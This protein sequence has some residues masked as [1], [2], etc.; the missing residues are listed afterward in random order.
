MITDDINTAH[1]EILGRASG[2]FDTITRRNGNQNRYTWDNAATN[3]S[4]EGRW[5]GADQERLRQ[6][7]LLQNAM[8]DPSWTSQLDTYTGALDTAG[9][10]QAKEGY[11][12]AEGQRRT[13]AASTGRSGGSW[14]AATAGANAQALAN[15]KA[16]V[17]QQVNELRAA[18]VRN[19]D[20]MGR[21]LLDGIIAGPDESAAMGTALTAEQGSAELARLQELNA[22]QYRGLLANT[23]A[24]FVGQA[25]TPAITAGFQN[26]DRWN[27]QQRNNYLDARDTGT[28]NGNYQSWL[29]DSGG[30]RTFWGW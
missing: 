28:Y 29:S 30:Q 12:Q 26:A 23:V 20:Q 10:T 18:G 24:G 16:Q 1:N 17:A 25:V 27:T 6:L 15:A 2:L 13:G 4:W 5:L 14:E 7:D 19:L 8:T 22:E 11:R 3:D 9:Q 21:Q